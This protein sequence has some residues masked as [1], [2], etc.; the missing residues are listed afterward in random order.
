MCIKMITVLNINIAILYVIV[1]QFTILTRLYLYD[2]LW[3]DDS[4]FCNVML[5]YA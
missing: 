1:R 3:K 4:W 2:I 5:D